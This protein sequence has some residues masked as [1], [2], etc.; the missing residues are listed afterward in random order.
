MLLDRLFDMVAPYTCIGC[1][2]EGALICTGCAFDAYDEVPDRCFRC[3]KISADAATCTACY[4]AAR[5]K[6]VWVSTT[7]ADNAKRLI[8]VMKLEACR[9]AT[10]FIARSLDENAPYFS[11]VVVTYA[12]TSPARVRERGFDHAKN[13][14]T[15]FARLRGLPCATLLARSGSVK[16]AGASRAERMKQVQGAYRST[17]TVPPGTHI[18]LIDDV[19]TTGATICEAAKVLKKAGASQVD[20][21]IFAQTI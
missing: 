20:G 11:D 14:A 12:P 9:S 3:F 6:H 13:I 18:V 19:L 4:P 21:L 15:E 5:L 1:G 10:S 17:A 7:Y 8:Q 2:Q 16:Q